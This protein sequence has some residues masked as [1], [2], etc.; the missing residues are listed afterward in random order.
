MAMDPETDGFDYNAAFERN[1]GWFRKEDQSLL[2][3]KRIAI[4]GL[5]GVGGH[6]LHGFLRLGF[7]KF[8]LADFDTFAIHNFNRQM[9]STCN[10]LGL[11]KIKVSVDFAKSVNPDVDI[12]A[13]ADGVTASNM[14][15]FLKDV[16]VVIDGLDIFAME[17]RVPLYEMAHRRGIPVVTAG[18]FGMGTSI[19][20]FSPKQMS[21][22]DYFDLSRANL[23]LEAKV[24]RFLAGITPNLMHRSYLRDPSW[25]DLFGHK[26]PSLNI[27]CLAAS[28][29]LGAMVVKILLDPENPKI[30]WAP[31]G[32]HVDFNLQKSVRFYCPWGNRN[33]IQWFKIKAYHRFFNKAEFLR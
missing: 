22:N 19:M 33:P 1:L 9:G 18:P 20:A 16:D 10:T 21:F 27:G 31:C 25:V 12:R 13:F 14:E 6:H 7:E 4:P 11:S 15:E 30:R 8:N 2:K 17:I 26:L 24:I 29:A 5:G 23:T 3:S 32:F 28:A